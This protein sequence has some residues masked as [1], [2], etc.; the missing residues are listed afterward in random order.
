MT[1][2]RHKPRTSNMV[3][4][5]ATI[6]PSGHLL[7]HVCVW[8]VHSKSPRRQLCITRDT[9][10][11]TMWYMCV[12]MWSYVMSVWLGLHSYKYK[13]CKLG[14]TLNNPHAVLETRLRTDR[15][16]CCSPVAWVAETQ[17]KVV[18]TPVVFHH[19]AETI[20]QRFYWKSNCLE[21]HRL[22]ER[23]TL[24]FMS[25]FTHKMQMWTSSVK[26]PDDLAL[27][28]R[29]SFWLSIRGNLRIQILWN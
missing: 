15:I 7:W 11:S 6:T 14:H 8:V 3:L 17:C 21:I 29:R 1:W 4:Q 5:C 22:V 25:A 20:L 2:P 10:V 27:D 28:T 23:F 18:H 12:S 26:S 19:T 16:V 9:R 13:W 24:L